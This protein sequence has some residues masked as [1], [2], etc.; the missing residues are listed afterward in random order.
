MPCSWSYKQTL[1]EK[2]N[3]EV[4]D[5]KGEEWLKLYSTEFCCCNI[6]SLVSVLPQVLLKILQYC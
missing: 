2:E 4:W 1:K 3:R 5:E 6:N